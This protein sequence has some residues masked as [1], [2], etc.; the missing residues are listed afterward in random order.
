MTR[1]L[2][3]AAGSRAGPAILLAVL[4]ATGSPSS[5]LATSS[6]TAVASQLRVQVL[7]QKRACKNAPA[8]PARV[9]AGTLVLDRKGNGNPVRVSLLDQPSATVRIRGVGPVSAKLILRTPRVEVV[10]G[11]SSSAAIQLALGKDAPSGGRLQ[12]SVGRD[13]DDNAHVNTLIVLQRAARVAAETSPRQLQQLTARVSTG[14]GPAFDKPNVMHTGDAEWEPTPLTHEYGHFVLAELA[15][16][17]FRG[18]DHHVARSYRAQ[19]FL[20]WSEGFPAAFAAV[21]L[22]EGN[23]SLFVECG[24]PYQNLAASPAS[25]DLLSASDRRFAQHNETRV[26]AAAYQLVQR[27]GGA[28]VGLKKLLTAL[29]RYRRAGHAVWQARDLRDLAAGHLART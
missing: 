23:G 20:A 24:K 12:F 13:E 7:Y 19:P 3:G 10:D 4:A 9:S 26:G 27:F 21:V 25:P 11:Q 1:S 8:R 22:A 15:P 6:G 18:G 17:G 5:G 14:A 16:D 28:Q 29:T 2:G